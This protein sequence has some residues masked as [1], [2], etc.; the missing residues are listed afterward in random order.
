MLEAALLTRLGAWSGLSLAPQASALAPLG[1][2]HDLRWLIVY[3]DSWTT[4]ALEGTGLLAARGLLTALTV[5]AA[6]PANQARPG[7]V[8][9]TVRAT[10]FTTAASV[11]LAPWTVLLFG[12]AVA[13]VSWLFFASVPAVLIVALLFHHGAVAPGWWRQSLAPR[14]M[15]WLGL[16]FL[17][18]SAAA[19][20]ASA[21]PGFLGIPVAALTGLFNA[22]AW[23][24][25]VHAVTGHQSARRFR[26]VAPAGLTSLFA[27]AMGGTALGFA[28]VAS[29]A[30]A[31]PAARPEASISVAPEASSSVASKT[32]SSGLLAT[33]SAT[34]ANQVPVL[35]AAGYGSSW[36]GSTPP[37]LPGPYQEERFSYR[38]LGPGGRPLGYTG[39]DTDRPL[40]QL[41]RDM[42]IQVDTLHR[43]T[44]RPVSIVAE[45][46]GSLVAK[47]YLAADPGAPVANLVMV[48]PLV[49]PARVYYPPTG[50]AG[51]GLAGGVAL[52]GLSDTIGD[53]S[54]IDLS[55]TSPFLRSV[56][57]E[58][59][60]LRPLLSCPLPGVRQFALLP[61]ADALADPD[62]R[63]IR[64]PSIVLPA[65]HGG[66]LSNPT[67]DRAIH[68]LLSGHQLVPTPG[69]ALADRVIRS[70]AAAWQVPELA[71]PLNPAWSSPGGQP[72]P[73]QSPCSHIRGQLASQLGAL[74]DAHPFVHRVTGR[75]SG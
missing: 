38:G 1:T 53:V 55:P 72:G 19:E 67:A 73:V 18:L 8:A 15:G 21:L 48:S 60:L 11:L 2:F 23:Y 75:R 13:P 29:P 59:P 37:D 57:Q 22:W 3:H 31:T 51:W 20:A 12:L 34:G 61:L 10:G 26:P 65:F 64:I 52:Q 46:E 40:V 32:P 49:Q 44:G 56:V 54:P 69:W 63:S 9:L 50:E 74:P 27:V 47:A 62:P 39:A 16:S 5:R 35:I 58:A 45:S 28:V 33:G 36:D 43:R 6:W 30:A 68:R 25:L 14:A 42:A 70:A 17:V 4:L 41:E 66:M 7:L 71:L 24:G